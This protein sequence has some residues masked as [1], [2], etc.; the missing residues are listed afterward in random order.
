MLFTV[1]IE[2]PKDNDHA[3]GIVV[4]VFELVGYGCVSAAD[5][6]DQILFRAKEVILTMVEEVIS[7]GL[8]VE[9][10]E[11]N[12]KNYRSEYPEFTEWLCLEIDVTDLKS[13]PKR[14]NITLPEF[15]IVKIDSYVNFNPDFKDRSD[16]LSKAA[17]RLMSE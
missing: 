11:D 12:Y 5:S 6:R 8:L 16:F 4:P 13:K 2:T 3:F 1:G 14:I 10:L 17:S 15:Q 7:D 9:Q